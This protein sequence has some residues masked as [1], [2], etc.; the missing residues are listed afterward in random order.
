MKIPTISRDAHF[1]SLQFFLGT[2]AHGIGRGTMALAVAV[3]LAGATSASAQ[4]L[5]N[6]PPDGSYDAQS[7]YIPQPQYAYAPQVQL[8]APQGY[9]QRPLSPQELTQLVAPIALYPDPLVAQILAASTY[10]AQISAA[11]QWRRSIGNAPAEQI[12]AGADAQ[13]SWDP[14]VKALTAF[15]QVLA[16]LNQNLQWTT[17]LGNAYYNQPQDLLQTIQVL[18]QR[19][20]QAGNLQSTPQEQVYDNQGAIDIAPANPQIVYV[21]A[22]DPWS[23]YGEPVTPYP[24]FSLLGEIGS[25]IGTGFMHFGPGVAMSAFLGTPWGWLGWGLDWLAHA[26]LFHHDDYWTNSNSVRDWGFPRGGPRWGGRDWGRGRESGWD[27]GRANY[28]SHDYGRND[29]YGGS[30]LRPRGGP[31]LPVR[32]AR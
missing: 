5:Q 24:G 12:A 3:A 8:Y 4:Q 18:R 26:I 29:G 20:E 15:P 25:W 23:A 9:A 30:V 2:S 14:S 31:V 19:A 11:D 28:G 32:D 7:Q 6:W 21:P 17:S 16:M 27:G 13:T 1:C 10:P 22:Y